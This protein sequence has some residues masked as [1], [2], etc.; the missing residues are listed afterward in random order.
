MEGGV[1]RRGVS[2]EDSLSK[3]RPDNRE[4]TKQSEATTQPCSKG[5][6]G[7]HSVGIT[8]H[9]KYLSTLGT[10]HSMCTLL[11]YLWAH[12][13]RM[14]NQSSSLTV[15]HVRMGVGKSPGCALSSFGLESTSPILDLPENS[16][17]TDAVKCS[18]S[19]ES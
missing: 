2:G 10:L 16:E 13:K 6:P 7:I 8:C 3:S 12:L 14:T 18:V 1:E 5:R 4:M 19:F 15:Y 9:S 17:G 11:R